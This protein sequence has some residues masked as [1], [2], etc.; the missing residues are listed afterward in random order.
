MTHLIVWRAKGGSALRTYG[1][2]EGQDPLAFED[3]GRAV[4]LVQADELSKLVSSREP[5]EKV[6]I[7][8]EIAQS[9]LGWDT[10]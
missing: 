5:F 8:P 1:A 10:A 9:V 6:A 7:T 2:P 4:R 3:E